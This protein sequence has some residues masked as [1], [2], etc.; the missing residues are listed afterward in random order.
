MP[1]IWLGIKSGPTDEDAWK[2]RTLEGEGPTYLPLDVPNEEVCL[3]L[4]TVTSQWKVADCNGSFSI[5]CQ[6]TG[7]LFG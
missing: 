4:D 2:W 6:T 3:F 5:L 1:S 7:E